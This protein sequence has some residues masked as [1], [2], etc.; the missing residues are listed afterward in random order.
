MWVSN[1]KRDIS[2]AWVPRRPKED[3]PLSQVGDCS[4][5]FVRIFLC[6][7]RI[8]NG[9]WMNSHWDTTLIDILN[10][11]HPRKPVYPE[12]STSPRKSP[13]SA[14]AYSLKALGLDP[15]YL[16]PCLSFLEERQSTLLPTFSSSYLISRSRLPQI[17]VRRYPCWLIHNSDVRFSRFSHLPVFYWIFELGILERGRRERQW[18]IRRWKRG[19]VCTFFF[20]TPNPDIDVVFSP[21]AIYTLSPFAGPIVGP[22]VSG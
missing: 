10:R 1:F 16:G 12:T 20:S 8:F 5:N 17:S 2:R 22:L 3:V 18:F 15:S 13:S 9:E 11:Q 19:K 6:H 14:S 4:G 21:M 7:L